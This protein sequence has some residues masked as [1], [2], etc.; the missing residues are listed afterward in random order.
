[1]LI[2]VERAGM[3]CRGNR[4]SGREQ[5][6][7]GWLY[8]SA[9]RRGQRGCKGGGSGGRLALHGWGKGGAGEGRAGRMR[10]PA[11]HGEARS[12]GDCL[13]PCLRDPNFGDEAMSA[14]RAKAWRG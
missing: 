3:R 13:T 11:R 14:T 9:R 7:H 5:Q 1:M 12:L 8:R 10:V 4:S 2:E 6:G